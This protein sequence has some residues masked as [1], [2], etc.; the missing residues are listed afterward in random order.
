MQFGHIT[1]NPA[2]LGGKPIIK[3]SRISVQLVLEW[4]VARNLDTTQVSRPLF[5][6]CC[7]ARRS[8]SPAMLPSRALPVEKIASRNYGAT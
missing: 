7:V 5:P 3:G 4:L 2:I 6:T 1:S 8:Q